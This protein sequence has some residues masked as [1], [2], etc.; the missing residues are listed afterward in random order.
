MAVT[1]I[2]WP[3]FLAKHDMIWEASGQ[4]WL[5]GLPLGN[6]HIGAMLWGDGAPLT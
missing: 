2:D 1:D 3:A 4:R 5:D 6:G